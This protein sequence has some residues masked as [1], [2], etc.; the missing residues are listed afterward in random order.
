MSDTTI[1]TGPFSVI[2]PLDD[3]HEEKLYHPELGRLRMTWRVRACLMVLQAYLAG[4]LL[5]L[6]W[7]VL[8]GL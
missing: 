2:H 1:Q 3:V 5:M 8:T 7:R 4:M 6:T